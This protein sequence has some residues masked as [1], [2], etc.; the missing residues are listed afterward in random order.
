M[1]LGTQQS[2]WNAIL[3]RKIAEHAGCIEEIFAHLAAAT[4]Q[5][6]TVRAARDPRLVELAERLT[7]YEQITDQAAE[8]KTFLEHVTLKD[9]VKDIRAQIRSLER[10]KAKLAARVTQT[11]KAHLDLLARYR[12]LLSLP[13]A[14]PIVAATLVV[15]MPE[16]GAM[17]LTAIVADDDP[18]ASGFWKAAGYEAQSQRARFVKLTNSA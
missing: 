12:L 7:T 13:G 4:A 17:R 3:R 14:G 5:V 16:L 9:V 10:L 11:I 1:K 6:D 2:A 18:R 15:R 8:L